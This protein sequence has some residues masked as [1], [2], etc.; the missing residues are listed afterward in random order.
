MSSDNSPEAAPSGWDRHANKVIAGLALVLLAVGT[1]VYRI[2]EGWEWID[3]LYFCTVA[4]TTVGFGDLTPTTSGSKLFTVFYV[5]SGIALIT[6]YL[7][8]LGRRVVGRA[9]N[10]IDSQ[11]D[12]G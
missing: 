12:G 4:L 11:S 6:T 10:R 1:A 3:S 9:K 7:N 2:V 5:L 8:L